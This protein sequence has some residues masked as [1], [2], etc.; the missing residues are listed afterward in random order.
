MNNIYFT[1]EFKQYMLDHYD[2]TTKTIDRI[3]KKFNMP[4][5]V[6][7]GAAKRL[8]IAKKGNRNIWSEFDL[9][10]LKEQWGNKTAQAI[11]KNLKRT[12][13]AILAMASKLDLGGRKINYSLAETGRLLGI[14]AKT[15]KRWGNKG[16]KITRA[17]T[18]EKIYSIKLEDLEEFLKSY[19]GYWDSRKMKYSLWITEPDWFKQRKKK[20]QL[21]PKKH[22][23]KWDDIQDQ[24]LLNLFS[25]GA[26]YKEIAK[27]LSRSECAVRQHLRLIDFGR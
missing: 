21:R 1:P 9:D 4:R 27:I 12:Q 25:K 2:G 14:T 10:F 8:H 20:D 11:G 18:D 7:T 5:Y 17:K 23:Y 19:K 13:I 15:V 3:Q 24:K 16:L 6:I 26:D 22:F